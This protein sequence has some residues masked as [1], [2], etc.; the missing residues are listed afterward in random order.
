MI[1]WNSTYKELIL[2]SL[3]YREQKN[4]HS[5]YIISSYVTVMWANSKIVSSTGNT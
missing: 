2:V 3:Q 4:Y 5:S 1:I